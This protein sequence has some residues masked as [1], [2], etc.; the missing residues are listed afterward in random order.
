MVFKLVWTQ[1]LEMAG[2]VLEPFIFTVGSRF[3]DGK[4]VLELFKNFGSVHMDLWH[5]DV[6]H[7]V[8]TF[9][10]LGSTTLLRR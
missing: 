5:G 8:Q 7:V 4:V 10:M 3:G 9:V 6:E 2:A 1:V